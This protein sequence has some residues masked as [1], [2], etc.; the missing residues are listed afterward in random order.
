MDEYAVKFLR[1]SRFA[2]YMVTDEEKR[3]SRFQQGLKMNVQM[4]LIPQQLKTYSQVLTITREVERGLEKKS[5][6]QVRNKPVKRTFPLMNEEDAARTTNGP[7]IKRPFQPPLQQIICGY[8]RKPGHIQRN[9]RKANGLCLVCGSRNHS[10][11]DCPFKRTYPIPP[12]FPA[13]AAPPALP[14]PPLRRSQEPVSRR[15]PL[16]AQQHDQS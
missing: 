11:G 4:F 9:C 2:P 5:K 7:I 14:A 16:S 1:L 15:V 13:R 8:C 10:I 3:V 12:T 6:N